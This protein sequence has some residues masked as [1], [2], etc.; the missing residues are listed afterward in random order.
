VSATF[1]VRLADRRDVR[2]TLLETSKAAIHCLRAY[3]D[4]VRVRGEKVAA[5]ERA[6]Q[7]LRG[8][9]VLLNRF[10][11]LLPELSEADLSSIRLRPPDQAD[12]AV[13]GKRAPPKSQVSGIA[14]RLACIERQL[15]EL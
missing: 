8:L 1:F 3:Q 12:K 2:R 7:E 9:T 5:I 15:G 6:R 13:K 14:E 10:E 11:K 4:L